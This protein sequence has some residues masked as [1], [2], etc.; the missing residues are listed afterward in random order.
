MPGP[1]RV[2]LVTG[3]SGG[4][5][6]YTALGL[7]RAGFHVVLAGRDLGRTTRAVRLIARRT[8]SNALTTAL[9]DFA[10]LGEVRR[11][12]ETVLTEHDRLDVLVNNAGLITPRFA[13]TGDGV[14]TT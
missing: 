11:L 1:Q 9:A 8:G 5:G 7:A 2:A 6:L 14:E 12:A 13:L 4:I 10:N 3:A